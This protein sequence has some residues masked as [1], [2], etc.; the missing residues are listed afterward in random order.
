MT[1]DYGFIFGEH[2]AFEEAPEPPRGKGEPNGQ[3]GRTK[4]KTRRLEFQNLADM[5][6]T[7]ALL[8]LIAGLFGE[9]QLVV[10]FGD[11]GTAK[12]LIALSFAM[13]IALGWPFCGRK[14]KKGFVAYLSP[15][16]AAS[17]A[18]RAR[19]WAKRHGVDLRTVPV[20][21]LPYSIDLCHDDTDLTEIMERIRELEVELG[22]CLV[23]VVDT[24][25]RALAGGDEN[26]PKDMG[27][28]VRHVDVLRET[29]GATVVAIHHTAVGGDE[30][31]GHRSL[32]NAGDVRLYVTKLADGLS[33]LEVKHAKDGP[34][35]E[36]LLFRVETEEVG[37]D[38]N[39]EPIIG[40][41]VLQETA[42]PAEEPGRAPAGKF[43]AAQVR[44]LQE[45]RKQAHERRSWDFTFAEFAEVCLAAG[46]L[47]GKDDTQ[48]RG[49][50]RDFRNQLANKKALF[51][52]GKAEKVRLL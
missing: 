17:I 37:R 39:E 16:G 10:M 30:P 25:S 47:E 40:A 22:P 31:R 23:V 1:E 11:S 43:T 13:H 4:S 6:F 32:R 29:V 12:S 15:E 33:Q 21:G 24:V 20:R 34:T 52:D 28:F 18:L 51:V 7:G 9:R 50:C 44:V 27:M 41:L 2:P 36:K 5:D 19:A 46:V 3:T 49:A 42:K 14:V 38:Q 45:L 8:T 48:R 35:G 26:G